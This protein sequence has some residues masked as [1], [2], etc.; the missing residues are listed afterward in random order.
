MSHGMSI[1]LYIYIYILSL[2]SCCLSWFSFKKNYCEDMYTANL[3]KYWRDP[4]FSASQLIGI[5]QQC[6]YSMESYF[7]LLMESF[8]H[9]RFTHSLQCPSSDLLHPLKFTSSTIN[10]W[11]QSVAQ[12]IVFYL[13]FW[14]YVSSVLHPTFFSK[15]LS[16]PL[17]QKHHGLLQTS[18][19]CNSIGLAIEELAHLVAR[20]HATE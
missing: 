1:S 6:I 3:G 18:F 8:H 15:F 12:L 14:P 10:N 16:S 5:G 9:F 11:R 20:S 13:I 17:R 2:I 4:F 7:N 19:L